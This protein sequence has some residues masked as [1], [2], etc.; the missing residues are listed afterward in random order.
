MPSAITKSRASG[1]SN[2]HANA[3]KHART[4]AWWILYSA[5]TLGTL[6][7]VRKEGK[8]R[9]MCVRVC[10]TNCVNVLLCA[11]RCAYVGRV[12]SGN[13]SSTERASERVQ[14]CSTC[15]TAKSLLE[16]PSWR[17]ATPQRD[18]T[19]THIRGAHTQNLKDIY[20][21][22]HSSSASTTSRLA[23]PTTTES[24]FS[25]SGGELSGGF[26][27]AQRAAQFSPSLSVPR[28]HVPLFL[29]LLPAIQRWCPVDF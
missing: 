1:C 19:N 3:C 26:F 28:I 29:Y 21:H 7:L 9:K 10:W 23:P 11:G 13:R 4:T 15:C 22:K 6:S 18:L 20:R 16:R 2:T 24:I 12:G 25:P 8:E 14:A 5:L 27:F 17:S